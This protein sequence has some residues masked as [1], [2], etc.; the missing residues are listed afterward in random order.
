ML[1]KDFTKNPKETTFV[2]IISNVQKRLFNDSV[3]IGKSSQL[4]KHGFGSLNNLTWS[5]YHN[6]HPSSELVSFH[7]SS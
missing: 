3:N 1:H 5:G 7:K 6:E 4:G 2:I